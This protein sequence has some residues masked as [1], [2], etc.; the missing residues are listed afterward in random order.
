MKQHECK[1]SETCTCYAL[2]SEPSENCPVHGCGDWPPRCETCGRFIKR[3][4]YVYNT[5]LFLQRATE[6]KKIYER[7]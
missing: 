4:E 2:A 5:A 6:L 3:N 1:E 7:V